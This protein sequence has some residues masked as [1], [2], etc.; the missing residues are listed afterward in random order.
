[1]RIVN[2]I[3]VKCLESKFFECLRLFPFRSTG[4]PDLRRGPSTDKL[5]VGKVSA[6][7][8]TREGSATPS[9]GESGMKRNGLWSFA[10]SRVVHV[11]VVV[12]I[13]AVIGVKVAQ[14]WVI[15]RGN[16]AESDEQTEV[17][18]VALRRE[19]E[20]A[21]ESEDWR[22]LVAISRRF[23]AAEPEMPYGWVRLGYGLHQLKRCEDALVA[24]AR[25]AD[26]REVRPWALYQ[27]ALA[28]ADLERDA[29]AIGFLQDALRAG[30]KPK[31]S[32]L[33]E[34][35]FVRLHSNDQFME[36]ATLF[37][38]LT[39]KPASE[40]LAFLEGKWTVLDKNDNVVGSAEFEKV[41]DGL[42]WRGLFFT[43]GGD[44]S[45]VMYYYD[46]GEKRW[47]RVRVDHGGAVERSA[48]TV[49]PGNRTRLLGLGELAL[50][51]ERVGIEGTKKLVRVRLIRKSL[52]EVVE[53]VDVSGDEGK[54][55]TTESVGTY[56][57][58]TALSSHL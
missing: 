47:E 39:S 21:L 45:A 32:V 51:G 9:G 37:E 3:G 4:S 42:V 57:R 20:Q 38:S 33:A 50:R 5:M 40:Q 44:T 7:G 11:I 56:R 28:C 1:M 34:P 8:G 52:D 16:V 19:S 41:A 18:T 14:R 27:M 15:G 10:L 49:R 29:D 36:V 46:P 30:F 22:R 43:E 17:D 26:F 23:V 6:R 35:T 25:C 48:G 31:D 2:Q 58:P 24:Y 13:L 55:W 54:T 53:I 12:V